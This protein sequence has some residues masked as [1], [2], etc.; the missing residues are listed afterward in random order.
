MTTKFKQTKNP[1]SWKNPSQARQ[2][3]K[4]L[5]KN[6]TSVG[7]QLKSK[8]SSRKCAQD[9]PCSTETSGTRISWVITMWQQVLQRRKQDA[10]T[11]EERVGTSPPHNCPSMLLDR[12]LHP[13]L[14]LQQ[15]S[16]RTA[17]R[18]G[19]IRWKHLQH[20]TDTACRRNWIKFTLNSNFTVLLTNIS[21]KCGVRTLQDGIWYTQT[22]SL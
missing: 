4:G 2:K 7:K 16:K 19:Y 22:S 1:K 18:D 15:P 10:R 6:P 3:S 17:V 13:S 8:L 12:F 20:L 21:G 5:Q 9:S 14:S 11:W